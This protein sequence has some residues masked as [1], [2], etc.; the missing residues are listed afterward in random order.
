M[1]LSRLLA[2]KPTPFRRPARSPDTNTTLDS[3]L[4]T[5]AFPRL[6]TDYLHA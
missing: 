5:G 4:Q 2:R 6:R 1:A 3:Y